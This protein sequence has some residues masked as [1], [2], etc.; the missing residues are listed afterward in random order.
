MFI[1]SVNS[2]KLELYVISL[3]T[4]IIHIFEYIVINLYQG[5]KKYLSDL[6][7]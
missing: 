4:Q 1:E 5:L 6:E 7:I 3:A 2:Y